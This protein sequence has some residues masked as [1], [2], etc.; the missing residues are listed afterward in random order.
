M[1]F[2][3]CALT[4]VTAYAAKNTEASILAK[5]ELWLSDKLCEVNLR[6]TT[7]KDWCVTDDA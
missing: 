5:T 7:R 4:R 6:M 2:P 3:V 1:P